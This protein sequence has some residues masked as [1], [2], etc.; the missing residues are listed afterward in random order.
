LG[1][2]DRDL[3]MDLKAIDEVHSAG[4]YT[5]DAEILSKKFTQIRAKANPNAG[6]YQQKIAEICNQIQN[7]VRNEIRDGPD[8]E[9][10]EMTYSAKDPISKADIQDPVKNSICNHVYD[11]ESVKQ[12]ILQCKAH[13]QL[14]QCPVRSCPNK[15]ALDMAHMVSFPDFFNHIA[16]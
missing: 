3:D 8:M 15:R 11:R 2:V 1:E 13:K 9:V 16:K 4:P 10:M 14:C 12:F 6:R 5:E 7:P